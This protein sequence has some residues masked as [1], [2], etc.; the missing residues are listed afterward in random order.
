MRVCHSESIVMW[1]EA[2]VRSEEVGFAQ[3]GWQVGESRLRSVRLE[4]VRDS[5][6]RVS[7]ASARSHVVRVYQAM[8]F[9]C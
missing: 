4:S 8:R 6:V 9:A 2:I 5:L 7:L 1:E 3:D